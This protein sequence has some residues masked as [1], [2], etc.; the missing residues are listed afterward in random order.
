MKRLLFLFLL[1]FLSFHSSAHEYFFAF[2]EVNYDAKE[3]VIEA[4]IISSAHETEDALNILG[5][6][7][8]ELEDHYKDSVMI[9]QLESFVNN[10]FSMIEKDTKVQFKLI[11][12]EV[13]NRGMVNF[14][15]KSEKVNPP[16]EYLVSFDLLMDQFPEQQNKVLFTYHNKTTTAVFL[17]G[18]RSEIIK[19]S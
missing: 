19:L 15:L 5:I 3:S 2:A 1:V 10:G 4:T 13:D 6:E 8:K 7:I 12:F 18:K 14:Y 11:G 16:T 9:S 17:P